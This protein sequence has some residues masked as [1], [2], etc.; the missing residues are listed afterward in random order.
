MNLS[1]WV[2]LDDL[3]LDQPKDDVINGVKVKLTL[4]PFEK[5]HAI[6][7]YRD[8]EECL[9]IIEFKYLNEFEKTKAKKV[10]SNLTF[11]V[12]RKTNRIYKIALDLS[13]FSNSE[14]TELH[15]ITQK[16]DE[17][18]SLVEPGDK[19][20]GFDIARGSVE[21]FENDLVQQFAHA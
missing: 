8:D 5:P 17:F 2:T 19:H 20:T 1:E 10:D 14:I 7:A 4:S 16:I 15:L 9:G 21:H 3:K 11:Y 18:E 6:R 12:G 13:D